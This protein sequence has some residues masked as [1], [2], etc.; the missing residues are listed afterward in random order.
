MASSTQETTLL[1]SGMTEAV[2]SELDLHGLPPVNLCTIDNRVLEKPPVNALQDDGETFEINFEPSDLYTDLSET[3]LTFDF[4]CV[5]ETSGVALAVAKTSG[6]V[7]NLF[8]S[9]YESIQVLVNNEKITGNNEDYAYKAWIANLIDTTK[10][11]KESVLCNTQLYV[12]DTPG[13]CDTADAANTGFVKRRK[14]AAGGNWKTLTGRLCLD[15]VDQ[16]KYI[17]PHTALRFI[18]TRSKPNFYMMETGADSFKIN[19]RN[20]KLSL[21]RIAVADMTVV[22]HAN[23]IKSMGPFNYDINRRKVTQYTLQQGA[24]EHQIQA[25]DSNQIPERIII[26]LVDKDA[27]S[28]T[29]GKNPFNFQHYKL[30]E[31]DVSYNDKKISIKADFDGNNA[32]KAFHQFLVES[33]V[34]N[35]GKDIGVN[36]KA[37]LSGTTLFAFDL[38]PDRAPED[39]YRKNLVKYG[40]LLYTFKFKDNLP[41]AVAVIVFSQYDNLIQIDGSGHVVTDYNML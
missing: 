2:L 9:L 26:G 34:Y 5:N 41:N 32:V 24:A 38:T 12:A 6:P 36:Y 7:S 16:H 3:E 20:P 39:A 10:H 18:F 17:P 31:I 8:H 25:L 14:I 23:H 15:I 11:R 40:T 33:G 30:E 19:I 13:Q 35:L 21:R 1:H 27:A 29:K 4:K 37:F 22:D 28:G